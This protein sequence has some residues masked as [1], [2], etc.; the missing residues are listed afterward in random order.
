MYM[1]ISFIIA[2]YNTEIYIEKCIRSIYLN[3]KLPLNE[4]EVIVINDG[5][6]DNGPLIVQRLKK[7]FS[8]ITLI[9]KENGGQSSARNIGFNVAKGKYLFCLDSDDFVNNS[10]LLRA[11]QYCEEN[12][13]DMLPVAIQ[14]FDESYKPLS[15]KKDGY[16]IIDQVITGGEFMNRYVVSGSMCRYFYRTSLLHQ[17]ELRLTEGIYH[18]DE[19]FVVKFMT[20]SHRVSYQAHS[21]YKQLVR[22]N[23][24]INN[25]DKKHR[26]KLLDDLLTVISQL[27]IHRK[28][29][30]QKTLE[31]KGV[32]KK[33]EQLSVSVFLRMKADKLSFNEVKIITIRLRSL[34]VYPLK[35]SILSLKFKLMALLFN[36][37]SFNKFY[38][39]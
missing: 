37:N 16:S 18:E 34:G 29:F 13:L 23:S 9:N 5:S 17:N 2:L 36:S 19:E 3:N 30:D 28:S 39:R 38:F 24:T 33:V 35:I 20:Y 10:E 27:E 25:R 22:H 7:E 15:N 26:L 21:V 6:T 8:N 11:L 12:T 1:R 4:Y 32:L 31:Y 14:A